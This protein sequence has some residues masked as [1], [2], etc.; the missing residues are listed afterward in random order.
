MKES[1]GRYSLYSRDLWST[2]L[3]EIRIARGFSQD[4]LARAA[5]I[6]RGDVSRHERNHRASNPSLDILLRLASALHVPAA[7]L[8]EIPGSPIP[9][10]PTRMT[11][12]GPAANHHDARVAFHVD[13]LLRHVESLG[14]RARSTFVQ[15]MNKLLTVSEQRSA[16][17]PRHDNQPAAHSVAP[18]SGLDEYE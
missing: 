15:T 11:T 7:A 8:F 2:R 1:E 12:P 10:V 5:G 9:A 16:A 13:G 3:R 18:V 6:A 14:H 4:A 17:P